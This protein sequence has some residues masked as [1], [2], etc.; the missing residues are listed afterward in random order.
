META[1]NAVLNPIATAKSVLTGEP[2]EATVSSPVAE[3]PAPQ[4]DETPIDP[5]NAKHRLER[6]LSNR[7]EK[8]ELVEKNILKNTNVA[9]ALHAKQEDLKRAQIGDKIDNMLQNRVRALSG[10]ETPPLQPDE[11]PID[12]TV[13]AAKLERKLT[14]RPDE[15]ELKERNILKNSNVAPALQGIEEGLKRAQLEDKLEHMLLQ[16]PK[17]GELVSEG[18]LPESEAPPS[19]A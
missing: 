15:Q 10:A 8:Q 3:S 17:P 9:P 4:P 7:P 11:T 19:H 18:I 5:T 6:Q 16:R 2:A 12:P 14:Q 13:S 1:K